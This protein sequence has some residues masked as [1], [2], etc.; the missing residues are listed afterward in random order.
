MKRF[1]LTAGDKYYPSSGSGDWI[2]S[3]DTR[4]DAESVVTAIPPDDGES[5]P[6][7][8]NQTTYRIDGFARHFDWYEIIDLSRWL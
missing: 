4:E 5:W 1:I 7:W 8:D 2:E 6:E 3:F